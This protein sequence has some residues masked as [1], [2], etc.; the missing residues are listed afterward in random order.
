MNND[1]NKDDHSD[2]PQIDPNRENELSY[3][4]EA[5]NISPNKLTEAILAT[6]TTDV[7]EIRDYL[8]RRG[9]K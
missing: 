9:E 3:A 4:A 1:R 8:K 6:G 7:S 2:Q 5:L